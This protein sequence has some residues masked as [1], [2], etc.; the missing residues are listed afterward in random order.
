MRNVLSNIALSNPYT[1]N[2]FK[3]SS[4]QLQ[5][6]KMLK[7]RAWAP[8]KTKLKA[9]IKTPLHS[10]L[11]IIFKYK[12][13]KNQ[14]LTWYQLLAILS[15]AKL[16]LG[17]GVEQHKESISCDR[18]RYCKLFNR[19]VPRY[20]ANHILQHPQECASHQ[21]QLGTVGLSHCHLHNPT[22]SNCTEWLA[23][24]SGCQRMWPANV[25]G[26]YWLNKLKKQVTPKKQLLLRKWVSPLSLH[27]CSTESVLAAFP[28]Q[29]FIALI[30]YLHLPLP[31]S[32]SMN[33]S[34]KDTRLISPVIIPCSAPAQAQRGLLQFPPVPGN[35]LLEEITVIRR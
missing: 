33:S 14:N 34:H 35:H 26:V 31:C 20:R 23:H 7:G 5:H 15:T 21:M 18:D 9:D 28:Q 27:I 25:R 12:H 13:C 8:E 6:L 16:I 29:I 32:A 1:A 3:E 22:I 10:D 19:K 17:R 4:T 24:S 30:L 11:C 2:L